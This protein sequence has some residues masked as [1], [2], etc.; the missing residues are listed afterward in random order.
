[1]HQAGLKLLF[2]VPA[3]FKGTVRF[4]RQ[5]DVG[6]LEHSSRRLVAKQFYLHLHAGFTSARQAVQIAAQTA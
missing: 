6:S 5:D 4:R 1:M 2:L 3:L